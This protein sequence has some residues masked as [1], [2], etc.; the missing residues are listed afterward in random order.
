M[1][2]S[3]M[4]TIDNRLTG[5]FNNGEVFSKN[6][7]SNLVNRNSEMSF[8]HLPLDISGQGEQKCWVI[9]AIKD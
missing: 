2:D 1:D 9:L 3:Q 8:Y 6:G 7:C 4:V 5:K